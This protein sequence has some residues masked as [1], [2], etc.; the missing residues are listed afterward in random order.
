MTD[1]KVKQLSSENRTPSR[2][3]IR[4]F[5]ESSKSSSALTLVQSSYPGNSTFSSTCG[6]AVLNLF[7]RM[8]PKIFKCITFQPPKY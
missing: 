3:E 8:T 4:I 2:G 5:T 1:K 6:T 7:S